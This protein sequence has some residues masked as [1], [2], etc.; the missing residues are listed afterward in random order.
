MLSFKTLTSVDRKI[1]KAFH[2]VEIPRRKIES[3]LKEKD[4]WLMTFI[5]DKKTYYMASDNPTLFSNTLQARMMRQNNQAYSN[6]N[7]NLPD[8]DFQM[9]MNKAVTDIAQT[10]NVILRVEKVNKKSPDRVNM[11]LSGPDEPITTLRDFELFVNT[12]LLTF[13]HA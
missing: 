13:H 10:S 2:A 6:W 4:M 7:G 3:V 11:S 12:E 1:I 9:G 5:D 8:E